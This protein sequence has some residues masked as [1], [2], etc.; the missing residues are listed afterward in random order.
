MFVDDKP[1]WPADHGNYAPFFI[2]LAWHCSGSSRIVDGRGGCD[3]ARIRF[4][5]ERSWDDNTNLDKALTLLT[6]IKEKYGLGLS[7]GDLITLTGTMAIKSM[8]G[9][10]LGFC[11]GRIDDYDGADSILLGPS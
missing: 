2:R 6:P 5:P 8:G 3:G 9:P 10:M 7:W 4:E 11:A 1:Y